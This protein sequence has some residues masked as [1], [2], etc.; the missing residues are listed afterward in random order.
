MPVAFLCGTVL[1]ENLQHAPR[2][3]MHA[4]GMVWAASCHAPAGLPSAHALVT[5]LSRAC[6]H[7]PEETAAACGS[8]MCLCACATSLVCVHLFMKLFLREKML[9]PCLIHVLPYTSCDWL[10]QRL[11]VP[12]MRWQPCVHPCGT[13]PC[14]C[15]SCPAMHDS[16]A[17]H[18]RL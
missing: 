7:A 6:V 12:G 5:M 18:L 11:R 3:T 9:H 13:Q 14:S 16:I 15:S 8:R 10:V 17:C 1:C 2:A 4:W